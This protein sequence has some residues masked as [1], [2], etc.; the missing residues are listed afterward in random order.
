MR[1]K[2]DAKY[3]SISDELRYTGLDSLVPLR[4]TFQELVS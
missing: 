2:G 3:D 4:M 1:A